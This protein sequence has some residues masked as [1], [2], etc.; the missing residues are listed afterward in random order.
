MLSRVTGGSSG[1]CSRI[2]D[3][4]VYKLNVNLAPV[5]QRCLTVHII[6]KRL[7]LLN[8]LQASMSVVLRGSAS[9]VSN[10]VAP[11]ATRV[12]YPYLY[13]SSYTTTSTPRAVYRFTT[14]SSS[15]A[16]L[17]SL[18]PSPISDFPLSSYASS[19]DDSSFILLAV[20][21]L[22]LCPMALVTTS[23]PTSRPA[24]S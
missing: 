22:C 13:P 18:N 9:S 21:S 12:T 11:S 24:H 7:I 6:D 4:C 10:P 1:Y 14:A 19:P 3:Q 23:M 20:L 2:C 15:V 17:S 5:S 16:L 8:L